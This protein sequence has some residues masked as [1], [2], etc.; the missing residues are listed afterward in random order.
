MAGDDEPTFANVMTAIKNI[1]ARNNVARD[2]VCE[3]INEVRLEM[4]A[5]R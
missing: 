1:Q 3:Q 2:E 4:D 5:L